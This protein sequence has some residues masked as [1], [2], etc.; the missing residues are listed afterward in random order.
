M[1]SSK[2]SVC[3]GLRGDLDL[4][5]TVAVSGDCLYPETLEYVRIRGR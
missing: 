1:E 5:E 4:Q 2:S 3:L